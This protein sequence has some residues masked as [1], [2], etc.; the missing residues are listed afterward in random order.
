M[1]N[2]QQEDKD[3]D[4]VGDVCDNCPSVQNRLQVYELLLKTGLGILDF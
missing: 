1:Y 2:P 3:G 4:G